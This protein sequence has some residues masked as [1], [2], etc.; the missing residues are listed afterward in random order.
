LSEVNPLISIKAWMQEIRENCLPETQIMVLGNKTDLFQYSLSKEPDID[1]EDTKEIE[2][3]CKEQGAIFELVS[4]KHQ[5]S[6]IKD[7][8]GRLARRVVESKGPRGQ[9]ILKL[10]PLTKKKKWCGV[11]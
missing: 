6:T 3:F 8:V 1:Q 2:D 9:S 10:L 4:A 5:Q 7:K 11:F